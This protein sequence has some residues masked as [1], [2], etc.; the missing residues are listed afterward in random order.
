MVTLKIERSGKFFVA[1]KSAPGNSRNFLVRDNRLAVLDDGDVSPEQRYVKRLPF[2]WPSWLLRIGREKTV[3]CAHAM[4]RGLVGR[5][6]FH[7]H[8]VTTAQINT[9]IGVA[10]TVDL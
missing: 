9:A 8:L 5:I 6:I 7:L 3:H 2:V 1:V 4:T 10:R